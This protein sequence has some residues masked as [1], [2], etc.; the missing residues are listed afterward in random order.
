MLRHRLALLAA[1]GSGLLP[2]HSAHAEGV[3]GDDPYAPQAPAAEEAEAKP[4]AASGWCA[5]GFETLARDV[6]FANP[7]ST[8][9]QKVRTLVV[10]FHGLVDAGTSWQHAQQKGM[11]LAAKRHGF[12]LIAPRGRTELGGK[13]K[14]DQIGWPTSAE[15]QERLEAGVLAEIAA[16]R[17]EIEDRQQAPFDEVFVLGFSNGAYY[18]A[19]LALRGKLDVAGYGVFAGGGAPKG[20]ERLAKGTKNRAPVFVGIAEKDTTKEDGK[21]L[22]KLLK[23]LKWP[24]KSVGKPVGHAVA[25]SH[26]ELALTFLR[27]QAQKARSAAS[28]EKASAEKKA[29]A[30]EP[31]SPKPKK[32]SKAAR[33]KK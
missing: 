11:L 27:D 4:A 28:A 23:S 12:Q 24:H 6:C 1:L 14:A 8:K 20:M 30:K 22:A 15:A 29:A 32:P 25:D 33:K 3:D 5:D 7:T 18:G 21:A 2:A 26:L 17:K 16:A 31:A 9:D 10:F 13:R 19:S